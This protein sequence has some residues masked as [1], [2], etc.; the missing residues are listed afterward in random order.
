MLTFNRPQA[1]PYPLMYPIGTQTTTYSVQLTDYTVEADATLGAFTVTMPL[2]NL[3]AGR[4]YKISKIDGTKNAVTVSGNG[5]NINSVSAITLT[6]IWDSIEIQ[7]DGTKWVM[8]T[9]YDTGS[10][11]ASVS[12]T[13]SVTEN[14]KLGYNYNLS[15]GETETA[16]ESLTPSYNYNIAALVDIE[17]ATENIS[18]ARHPNLISD[19]ETATENISITLA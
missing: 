2:A 15:L 19:T 1:A 8:F 6:N 12:D 3:A 13:E 14:V 17:T 10:S 11:V 4:I 9:N 5:F 16:T 7:S 18:L